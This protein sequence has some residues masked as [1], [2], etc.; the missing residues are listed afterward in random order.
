MAMHCCEYFSQTYIALCPGGIEFNCSIGIS[1]TSHRYY[2]LAS[3]FAESSFP[4]LTNVA[5]R[6]LNSIAF[7]GAREIASEYLANASPLTCETIENQEHS[8]LS[9]CKEI[10]AFFFQE[11][12]LR[13]G[14]LCH[15]VGRPIERI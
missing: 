6:L 3:V 7:C 15:G 8:L 11:L 9:S 2:R 12:P 4:I 13:G 10:I 1:F 5:A 14:F